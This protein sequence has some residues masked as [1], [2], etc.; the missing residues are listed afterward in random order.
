MD[1]IRKLQAEFQAAQMGGSALRLS[2]RNCIELIT[3]L[4]KLKLIRL[5]HTIDGKEFVTPEQI[6][7]EIKDE[8]FVHGGR[9]ALSDISDIL[10]IDIVNIEEVV[11]E[12]V[13]DDQDISW[14]QGEVFESYYMDNCAEEMNEKLQESGHISLGEL[15]HNFKLPAD[16]LQKAAEARLGSIIH[17]YLDP[18]S[19]GVIYTEAF[20]ARQKARIRGVF[21]AVTRPLN[22]SQAVYSYGFQE[23]LLEP[24]LKELIKDGRLN[25]T[26]QGGAGGTFVPSIY[27]DTQKNWIKSFFEQNSYI[28]YDTLERLEIGDGKSYMKNRFHNE[29]IALESCFVRKITIET[30]D[31]SIEEAVSSDSY[32][33]ILTLLP[34]SCGLSDCSIV[35]NNCSSMKK[36]RNTAVNLCDSYI[37]SQ[38]YVENLLKH[39]DEIVMTK[40]K[41]SVRGASAMAGQKGKT[42]SQEDISESPE[43]GRRGKGKRG[44]KNVEDYEESDSLRGGRKGGKRKGGKT[45]RDE[46]EEPV[47]AE[48]ETGGKKGKGKKGKGK[49]GGRIVEDSE[50]GTN[51]MKEASSGFLNVNEIADVLETHLSDSFDRD[52]IEELAGCLMKSLKASFQEAVKSVYTT[53]YSH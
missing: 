33:D 36:I 49:K 18:S 44:N 12:L 28:D 22:V 21:S 45:A 51:S 23:K 41:E 16:V 15:C 46:Y 14:I 43:S 3:K 20:L 29:G 17:G 34:T 24:F 38:A 39:F 13:K 2:D 1:E 52:V 9:V 35:L 53:W 50:Q 10:N 6:Q 32:V 42:K 4:K 37:F 11:S 48:V 8:L 7:R 47:D 25:G 19:K 26:L 27:Q 30:V 5:Y 31:A 40:A